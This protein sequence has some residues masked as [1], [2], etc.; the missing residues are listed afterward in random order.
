MSNGWNDLRG[1]YPGDWVRPRQNAGHWRPLVDWTEVFPGHRSV[2][3]AGAFELYDAPI[4]V[5]LAIEEADK[6]APLEFDGEA[7]GDGDGV[8]NSVR[9]W[10]ADDRYHL[11]YYQGRRVAYAVS[12]DAYRWTRPALGIIEKNGS[13]EN[14]LV[15]DVGGDLLKA[16]FEDPTAPPEE[17]FK[18]MGC[19]GAMI[20]SETG[21]VANEGEEVDE[22]YI[23]KWWADQEYL[24]PAYKGPS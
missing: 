8:G 24:G 5:R 14:N 6:S 23:Q 21:G 19:E 4:G 15:T 7:D 16:V 11:L 22:E 2:D 1:Y 20:N 3:R 10:Q 12:E 13:K 9:V 18:G 17:R